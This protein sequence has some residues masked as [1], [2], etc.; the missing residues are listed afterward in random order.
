[1]R[2]TNGHSSSFRHGQGC[3][4][5]WIHRL[6]P[7]PALS[8]LAG[9]L[10]TV[11]AHSDEL[12]A[13]DP[14]AGYVAEALASNAALKA[15]DFAV[16]A[17]AQ[18]LAAARARRAPQLAL[19]ARYTVA[20]GGR[21]T[22][23]PTGD[24]V[25]PIYQTLNALTAGGANP[26]QFPTIG[27][28]DI[29]FLRRTEQDT[30]LTLSAPLYAPQ[31]SAQ[32]GIR[33]AEFDGARAGREAFARTLVRDVKA[34]YF[35]LAQA[36]AGVE[37]LDASVRTL[38]EN[39]RV[40]EALLAAGKATRDRVL[41]AE[42][43]LLAVD[44]RLQT[45]RSDERGA[46]RYL[47]LLRN[48]DEAEPVTVAEVVSPAVDG[49]VDG[50]AAAGAR[51]ELR[52][53]DARISAA[54][55]ATRLAGASFLPTLSL[56]ADS[57]V[58]GTGYAIDRDS[59]VSTASLVLSWTLFDFGG[60]RAAEAQARAQHQQLAA[61]RDDLRR[62]L[63]LAQLSADDQALTAER[64]LLTAEARVAAA[65]EGFRIAENK[66]D[67][68]QSSPIEFLDAERARTEA[69]LGRVIARSA[70]QIARAEQ[71]YTRARFPLSTAVSSA[72][73]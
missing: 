64:A 58:Q 72:T 11:T 5:G 57:G 28:T 6:R 4:R 12:P 19:N 54:D 21:V 70:L 13:A 22:R 59:D 33:A 3:A 65:E 60:R 35:Q 26:T 8:L 61:L 56:V 16:E 14:L 40:A 63:A 48:R 30:R 52:D 47:N 44:Q 1:M 23:I 45:A 9:L 67:A 27:N 7:K 66:R 18:G 10:L 31:I 36:Q 71:E 69:R 55:Q 51:P 43:E 42:A 68:G 24:L 46:R 34:A 49:I 38:A 73:P 53:L 39:R 50:A 15:Q 29:N 2:L 37:I 25:N 20:D 62:Q 32:I 41:R 17:A